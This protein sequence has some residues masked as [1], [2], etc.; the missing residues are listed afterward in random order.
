MFDGAITVI[1]VAP[2]ILATAPTHDVDATTFGPAT[3]ELL[4]AEA[5]DASVEE[6]EVDDPPQAASAAARVVAIPRIATRL[7]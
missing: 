4:A 7:A 1:F 2:A 6:L 3:D 5:A